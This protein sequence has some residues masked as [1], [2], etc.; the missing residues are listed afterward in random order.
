MTKFR[1]KISLI[2]DETVSMNEFRATLVGSDIDI[3]DI[4]MR[5]ESIQ[6]VLDRE[7]ELIE[8]ESGKGNKEG[9]DISK[10]ER[11]TS[12][13]SSGSNDNSNGRNNSKYYKSSN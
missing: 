11:N 10:K 9:L 7:G 13:R 1:I 6:E 4:V 5:D 8:L 12:S 3:T 2:G